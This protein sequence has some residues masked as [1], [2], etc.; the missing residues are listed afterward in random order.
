[1]CNSRRHRQCPASRKEV[2]GGQKPAKTAY[3][4]SDYTIRIMLRTLRRQ[5]EKVL[6]PNSRVRRRQERAWRQ[7]PACTRPF[8]SPA[9]GRGIGAP[10]PPIPLPRCRSASASSVFKR[11][12]PHQPQCSASILPPYALRAGRYGCDSLWPDKQSTKSQEPLLRGKPTACYTWPLFLHTSAGVNPAGSVPGVQEAGVPPAGADSASHRS[13]ASRPS[14]SLPLHAASHRLRRCPR[15]SDVGVVLL[16]EGKCL[17]A[18]AVVPRINASTALTRWAVPA[19]APEAVCPRTTSV[20]SAVPGSPRSPF[21]GAPEPAA[22]TPARPPPGPRS[23]R[24]ARSAPYGT[25][26]L[27]AAAPSHRRNLRVCETASTIGLPETPASTT[28]RPRPASPARSDGTRDI[29]MHQEAAAE[30][31]Q[32]SY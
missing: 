19:Q 1:M 18:N 13:G 30:P 31:L 6:P 7:W 12:L 28:S 23:T 21:H 4:A 8:A 16:F 15:I 10:R 17:F 11:H 9:P 3:R 32:G 20:S 24:F 26:R 14:A 25:G 29:N 27:T 5:G 2:S 22:P